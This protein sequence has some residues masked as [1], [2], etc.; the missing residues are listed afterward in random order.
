MKHRDVSIR[1]CAEDLADLRLKHARLEN[2]DWDVQMQIGD[3]FEFLKNEMNELIEGRY[4]Q[5]VYDYYA[6]RNPRLRQ[7]KTGKT[8]RWRDVFGD[9]YEKTT[10]AQRHAMVG[11][12]EGGGEYRFKYRF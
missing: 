9:S 3:L 4:S 7:V 12:V 11:L 2:E 6:K 1:I 5:A 8:V 10:P